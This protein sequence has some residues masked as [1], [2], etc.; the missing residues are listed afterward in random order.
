MNEIFRDMGAE[1]CLGPCRRRLMKQYV[2]GI[3]LQGRY[4]CKTK[5]P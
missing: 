3:H 5:S 2:G 1:G 4:T